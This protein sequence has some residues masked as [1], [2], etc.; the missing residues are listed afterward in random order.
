MTLEDY[1]NLKI[2]QSGV[3]GD[4]YKIL[5]HRC[6]TDLWFLCNDVLDAFSGNTF[7]ETP[8]RSMCEFY[9][10]KDPTCKTFKEFAQKYNEP[11]DRIMLVPRQTRKSGIKIIDN[12]Q[13]IINWP[14]VRIMTCTATNSLSTAFINQLGHYFVVKGKAERDKDINRLVGGDWTKFQLLFP[15]HCI[16]ETESNQGEY[17]TP[18]RYDRGSNFGV[19]V[20]TAGTLSM[21]SS[22]SGWRCDVLDFDD[23]VSDRNSESTNQLEKLDN[24]IAMIFELMMSYGFRHTVATR[25]EIDD[26]YGKL[27]ESH[28]IKDG[29]LYGNYESD[30]LK[31]MMR[32]CWWL[33]GNPYAQPDYKTWEPKEEDVDL[34]Y[35]DGVPFKILAKK[36]KKPKVFSSQ[37]L[38]NPEQVV[39]V[40]FTEALMREA[41]V[42]HTALPKEGIVFASWDFAYGQGT[43]SS[44]DH[45]CGVIGMIDKQRRWWIMDVIY[46]H[47]TFTEK[48]YQV[49][50]AIKNYRPR[51]TCIEDTPGVKGAMTDPIDREAKK[52]KVGTDIDWVSAGQGQR[53]AKY[54]RICALHPW[55]LEHRLFF[56]NSIPYIDDLIREFKHVKSMSKQRNDIPD[57][58]AR[59]VAQYTQYAVEVRSPSQA[60]YSR[61]FLELA[62][63][64]FDNMMYRKGRYAEGG[65]WDQGKWSRDYK[66]PPARE[67]QPDPESPSYAIDSLFRPIE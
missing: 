54:L 65:D 62:E 24:R 39:S 21:D 8:H 28:G 19:T 6:Q 9:V 46:N 41:L 53:D 49:V 11:H 40:Q 20:A 47:F 5:R 1:C 66:A 45:S 56:L 16:T 50:K 18:M 32:P 26:P 37:Q 33:K 15:E 48:C 64:E 4:Q 57:A 30:G 67:E 38:N 10:K 36:M 51:R 25:Y 22:T 7:S 23:P 52:E 42:D 61:Q 34:F 43:S 3:S 35:P 29:K 12:V 13:W 44:E 58:I 60:E 14:E 31:A 55:L 27:L 63:V 59:L 17:I 2:K